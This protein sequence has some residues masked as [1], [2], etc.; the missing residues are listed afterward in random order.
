MR[1]VSVC[2]LTSMMG[3]AAPRHSPSPF[4]RHH[5]PEFVESRRPIARGRAAACLAAPSRRAE[6]VHQHVAHREEF[7]LQTGKVPACRGLNQ[8]LL[9]NRA[10]SA[11]APR[12]A[13]EH[14]RKRGRESAAPSPGRNAGIRHR[15]HRAPGRTRRPVPAAFP[16]YPPARRRPLATPTMHRE[17]PHASFARPLLKSP[18]SAPSLE[19]NASVWHQLIQKS[20]SAMLPVNTG[21]PNFRPAKTGHRCVYVVFSA[22][23]LHF[24]C[25]CGLV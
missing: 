17:P 25:G 2:R 18:I 21:Q 23:T 3:N 1:M 13:A 7:Q 15:P 16:H 8:R 4:S 19:Q 14:P 6:T 10:K 11:C 22:V 20:K 24:T 5:P 12:S 9:Q